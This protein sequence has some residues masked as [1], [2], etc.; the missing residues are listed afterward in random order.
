MCTSVIEQF[1]SLPS[2]GQKFSAA[3]KVFVG[4]VS[5]LVAHSFYVLGD[6]RDGMNIPARLPRTVHSVTLPLRC[7]FFCI[8]GVIS[9]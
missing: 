3:G 5:E 2:I 9:V 8:I 6:L 7:D 4:V 1:K